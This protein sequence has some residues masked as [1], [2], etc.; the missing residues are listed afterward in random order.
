M[1][2]C[3]DLMCGWNY[4]WVIRIH[5]FVSGGYFFI[6]RMDRADI[7]IVNSGARNAHSLCHSTCRTEGDMRAAATK[8]DTSPPLGHIEV[9]PRG[10]F[11]GLAEVSTHAWKV[12]PLSDLGVEPRLSTPR[13]QIFRQL[14]VPQSRISPRPYSTSCTRFEIVGE[15]PSGYQIEPSCNHSN[16]QSIYDS[17]MESRLFFQQRWLL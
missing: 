13:G 1:L 8:G 7:T 9:Y 17:P 5:G 11:E 12:I 15:C 3:F 6:F 4:G 10:N 14:L 2:Y 16:R